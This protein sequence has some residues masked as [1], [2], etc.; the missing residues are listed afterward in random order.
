METTG[1][2]IHIA[3]LL[4]NL[5]AGGAERVMLLLARELSSRGHRIHLVLLD[6]TGPLLDQIPSNI[7]LVNL[8]A[9]NF[10]FGRPGFIMSSVVQLVKWLNLTKPDILFSTITGSNIVAVI[11]S[12]LTHKTIKTVIREAVTLKNIHSKIR[13]LAMRWIYPHADAIVVLTKYMQEELTS[14]LRIQNSKIYCIKNPVDT[15]FIREQSKSPLDHPWFVNPKI[16]VIIAVGRLEPQKDFGTLL[17]AF[18]LVS[19]D[20]QARLIIVGEGSERKKLERLS[21]ELG[22]TDRVQLI[23]FDINPWKWISRANVFLMSSR[24]EGHPNAL[25][26]AI[27]LG[28]PVVVTEYDSSVHRI[29]DPIPDYQRQIVPTED[30]EKLAKAI[31]K[32]LSEDLD[33]STSG[34]QVSSSETI[35]KYENILRMLASTNM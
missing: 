21:V 34:S 32:I 4:P 33:F 31:E 26:E 29:F 17:R 11:A 8:G 27:T 23:G 30:P 15:Q 5:E 18:S 16:K 7:N 25:L 2:V 28:L 35:D 13:R 10:G 24:W 22:I 12:K 9:R 3:M 1:T 20:F 14:T 19:A 6:A